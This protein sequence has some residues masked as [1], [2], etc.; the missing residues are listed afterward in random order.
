MDAEEEEIPQ[1][2]EPKSGKKKILLLGA[3]VIGLVL[4]VGGGWLVYTKVGAIKG[5]SEAEQAHREAT[6]AEKRLRLSGP[7]KGIPDGFEGPEAPPPITISRQG[8]SV[9]QLLIIVLESGERRV[10][11]RLFNH[12]GQQLSTARVNIEF[13]S[14]SGQVVLIRPVNPLVVSGGIFGDQSEPLPPG[15]AR[16]FLVATDDTPASWNGKV[17]AKVMEARFGVALVEEARR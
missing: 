3:L 9:D 1:D 5:S 17:E 6:E 14:A 16:R 4:I 12:G 11:G 8:V 7:L 15:T 10:Q 13:L 2:E